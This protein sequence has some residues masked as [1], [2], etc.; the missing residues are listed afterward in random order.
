MTTHVS[1]PSS[2]T[3][4]DDWATRLNLPPLAVLLDCDFVE[5]L[6][7]RFLLRI[8]PAQT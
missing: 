1:L 3:D 4:L 6:S 8:N 5:S 2:V 7:S